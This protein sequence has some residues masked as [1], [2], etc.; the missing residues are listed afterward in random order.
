MPKQLNFLTLEVGS[1]ITKANGFMKTADNSLEHVA[2]GFAPTS[3]SKG[4]VGIG[5]FAAVDDLE[6]RSSYGTD[7]CE[8]FANSSAAGGLRVTVHGLTYNM[9]ARAAK[10][11]SLGAGAIIKKI[12][13]GELSE[14]DI[15]E[16]EELQPNMI[17]LAGG[18]DFG[19]KEIVLGNAMKLA[20]MDIGA[21]VVYAGNSAL[22]RGVETIFHRTGVEIAVVPNVFPDVDQLNVEPL[23][24]KMQDLFSKHIIHAPGMERLK[25]ISN[26]TIIPTPAAVL[27]ATEI[28]AETL[29][30]VVVIDVGGATTDVHSVTDG[31]KEFADKLTDPEPHSKR[32]VEGDLGVFVNAANIIEIS[33]EA[34]RQD[35]ADEVKAIPSS[36]S[37]KEMTSWLCRKAVEIGVRR[38]AAVVSEIFTPVGRRQVIKGKD[39]SAVKYVIGTGG[40]L[41]RVEGGRKILE[42]I[43]TGVGKY[44]MPPKTAQI[45]IDSDYLFSALGT[46]SVDYPELVKNTFKSWSEKH[47][48]LFSI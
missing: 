33:E 16:I 9:T 35:K 30:D 24:R 28:F 23:R 14:Y 43:C 44:L 36:D 21:P 7:T 3:V 18:V 32:S 31:S 12:T 34:S 37:E 22:K 6:K 26:H 11:A 39:L 1:T 42:S 17:V 15:D 20:A 41:T 10:E 40:A 5:I 8:V 47:D 48:K 4:N 38:H 13:A 46:M 29:G 19:A 25:A 2:Q 27:R 45:L